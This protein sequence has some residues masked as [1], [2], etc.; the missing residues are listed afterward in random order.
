MATFLQ[1]VT[2]LAVGLAAA[3]AVAWLRMR[4]RSRRLE[5]ERA[6]AVRRVVELE[7]QVLQ[8]HRMEA[9]GILAGSVVHNL[10]NLLAVILGNARIAA[11]ALPASHESRDPLNKVI[12][13]GTLTGELVSEISD[14]YRQVDRARKPTDLGP[15]VRDTLKLLRDILPATVEIRD[16]LAP[17]GPVL[18]SATGVQ[19]V[20]MHLGS[21]AVQALRAERGVIEVA[22]REELVTEAIPAVPHEL[23][24]G[25]YVLLSIRDDGR[26]M[27]RGTLDR[28]FDAYF[29]GNE[30]GKQMGLGLA[31]VCRIVGEH[32]GAAVP[33][34]RRKAGARFDIYFPLIAWSAVQPVDTVAEQVPAVA[35]TL[36]SPPPREGAA[37]ARVLLVDDDDM[38]AQVLTHGLR[39]L[40][41][42]VTAHTDARDALAEFAR[43]PADFDVVITDQIMPHMSGVRLTRRIHDIR[44]DVPVILCTGFRDSFNERQAR[45]AGVLD[46]MLK[47]GNHRDLAAMI[48][49]AV[50]RRDAGR[51]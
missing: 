28:I 19:Q 20:L 33:S 24:P 45:E 8:A 46:F 17:C 14:L 47:P 7:N 39:R 15:V 44:A 51:A 31:T 10:N 50:P 13:A 1:I 27:D 9:V 43:H 6:D 48:E 42:D 11:Q 49:R 4:G 32:E 29:S 16:D 25:R 5:R 21:N 38:V 23:A 3:A 40:N 36:P 37:L 30:D 2:L 18:A 34:N 22:M 12:S 41:Y 35:A 26:G